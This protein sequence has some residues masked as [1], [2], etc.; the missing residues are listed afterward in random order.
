MKSLKGIP[1]WA[2]FIGLLLLANLGL[3]SGNLYYHADIYPAAKQFK[4]VVVHTNDVSPW[5]YLSGDASAV[6]IVDV[7]TGKPVWVKWDTQD[8]GNRDI[9]SCFFRGEHVFDLYWTTNRPLVYG[10]YF[11]GPGKSLTWWQNRGGAGIFTQR[12]HYDTNGDLSL[13]EAWYDE[14]WH[15]IVRR[16]KSNGIVLNGQWH[17][18]A[19]DT[20]G[21][22]TTEATNNQSS[23]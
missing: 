11:H 1:W 13:N 23:Q 17:Q 21:M 6:G 3:M 15:P 14:A 18:L 2:L 22:W 12:T 4:V 7:K 20:N 16:N 5:P 9:Q 10:V 19:F 8:A